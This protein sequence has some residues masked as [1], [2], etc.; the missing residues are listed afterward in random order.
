MESSFVT[1]LFF[2]AI[3]LLVVVSGGVVYLTAIEWRDRRR[4]D[5]D[6]KM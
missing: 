1:V 2:A 3:S 4:Q 5:R 6:K